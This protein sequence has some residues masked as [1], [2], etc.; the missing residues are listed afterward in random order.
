MTTALLLIDIQNDYFAGGRMPLE[1]MQE[2]AAHAS[3]LLGAFRDRKLPVV[4]VRH[5]SVRPGATY[6]VPGTPGAGARSKHPNCGVYFI[7]GPVQAF[8]GKLRSAGR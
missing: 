5:L 8:C 2:A 3:L 4:H 6:F 7:V 1:R